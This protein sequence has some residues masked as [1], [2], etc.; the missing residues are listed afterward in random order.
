[1]LAFNNERTKYISNLTSGDRSLPLH[2][3]Q[4][5][6]I[7]IYC[8]WQPPKLFSLVLMVLHFNAINSQYHDYGV[9]CTL[10]VGVAKTAIIADLGL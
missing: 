7:L 3:L 10:A 6:D 4:Y 1:M 5:H 2:N 9:L 8:V